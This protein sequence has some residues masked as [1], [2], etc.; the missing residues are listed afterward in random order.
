MDITVPANSAYDLGNLNWEFDVGTSTS[1]DCYQVFSGSRFH[2]FEANVYVDGRA[3]A[4][5]SS[6]GNVDTTLS[7]VS[8]YQSLSNGSVFKLLGNQSYFLTNDTPSSK[9]YT[10]GVELVPELEFQDYADITTVEGYGSNA[11]SF[12]RTCIVYFGS[13]YSSTVSSLFSSMFT[14]FLSPIHYTSSNLPTSGRVDDETAAAL[15]ALSSNGYY[16]YLYLDDLSTD[17]VTPGDVQSI[18]D[19]LNGLLDKLN[20]IHLTEQQILVSNQSILTTNQSIAN[21]L[22][23]NPYTVEYFDQYSGSVVSKTVNGLDDA[24]LKQ[25]DAIAD[26]TNR[27]A[28]MS[29]SDTDIGIKDSMSDRE[30]AIAKDFLGEDSK[31]TFTTDDTGQLSDVSGE[32]KDMLNTGASAGDAFD[33]FNEALSGGSEYSWFSTTTQDNLNGPAVYSRDGYN[34]DYYYSNQDEVRRRLGLDG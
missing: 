24:L 28:Y 23:T 31:A 30:D 34:Y 13:K 21:A 20:S 1:G 9:T 7:L 5:G 15:S 4:S 18:L 16:Y 32:M 17:D 3:V 2:R 14:S 12:G 10:I 8:G 27:L 11:Y 19:A 33:S 25:G 22:L 29:G 26:A 6:A